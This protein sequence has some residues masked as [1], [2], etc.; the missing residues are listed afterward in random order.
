MNEQGL[1]PIPSTINRILQFE[2][3]IQLRISEA[4]NQAEARLIAA[5][6]E[7]AYIRKQAEQQG[8]KLHNEQYQNA[9]TAAKQE[10]SVII[11]QAQSASREL[12]E[13]GIANMPEV[14]NWIVDTIANVDEDGSS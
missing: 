6:E 3:S 8:K 14:V 11:A 2:E 9:L 10:A 13:R 1:S 12:K 4:H 7:A 5:H